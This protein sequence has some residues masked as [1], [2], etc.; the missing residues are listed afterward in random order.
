MAVFAFGEHPGVEGNRRVR[1]EK[2]VE[3]FERPQLICVMR[4]SHKLVVLAAQHSL[5][6]LAA[7]E[8]R[9]Q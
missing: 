5:G 7:L 4:I 6:P 1:P 2:D 3:S 9:A 8:E